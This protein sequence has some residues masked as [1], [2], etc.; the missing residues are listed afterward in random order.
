MI[1]SIKPPSDLNKKASSFLA[2][3]GLIASD[4]IRCLIFLPATD[5]RR[6]QPRKLHAIEK[7]LDFEDHDKNAATQFVNNI[8]NKQILTFQIGA[9]RRKIYN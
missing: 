9:T 7:G 4:I 6:N 3:G 2:L 8:K 1:C 5:G